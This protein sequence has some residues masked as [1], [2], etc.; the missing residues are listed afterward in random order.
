MRARSLAFGLLLAVP[1]GA[2][3]SSSFDSVAVGLKGA[4]GQDAGERSFDWGPTLSVGILTSDKGDRDRF[5]YEMEYSYDDAYSK[6]SSADTQQQSRVRTH[7]LKYAKLSL[8][9]VRGWDLKERLR[10]V[11]FVSGGVQYVDSRGT[12]DG[13]R[14]QDYYWAPTWGVGV[15]FSLSPKTT[16]GLV[17]DS[18]TLG[19]DRRVASVSLELKVAVLGDDE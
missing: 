15:D 18:N 16:L 17:Y 10:F 4:S 7:E 19:G 3:A 5:K 13:E 1:A 8:L 6:L 2:R 11:P 12:A 9:G 14:T